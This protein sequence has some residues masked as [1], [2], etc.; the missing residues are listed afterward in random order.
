LIVIDSRTPSDG[1]IWYIERF[2]DE[3]DVENEQAENTNTLLKIRMKIEDIVLQYANYTIA[4][5]DICEDLDTVDIDYPTPENFDQEMVFSTEFDFIEDWYL[6]PTWVVTA[7]KEMET[8]ADPEDLENFSPRPSIVHML[9]PEIAKRNSL[10][11]GLAMVSDAGAEDTLDGSKKTFSEGSKV[12]QLDYDP[13][14]PV[15]RYE[16][17]EGSP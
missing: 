16:R 4:N 14:K 13:E 8:S 1:G 6:S 11:S 17:P 7:Q 9:K 10:K 5:T 2:A 15:P 12:L 3:D